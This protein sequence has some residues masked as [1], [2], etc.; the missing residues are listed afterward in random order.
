MIFLSFERLQQLL[1][2]P[3]IWNLNATLNYK[4]Y[5]LYLSLPFTPM[6]LKILPENRDGSDILLNYL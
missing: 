5:F 1:F 3:L 4:A 6:M 2:K